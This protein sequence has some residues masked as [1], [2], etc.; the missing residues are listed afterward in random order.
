MF[1]TATASPNYLHIT[2]FPLAIVLF[3]LSLMA[4]DYLF[5]IFKLFLA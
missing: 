4:S 2:F 5:V 3:V 1:E